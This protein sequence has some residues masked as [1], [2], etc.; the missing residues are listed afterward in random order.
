MEQGK[1]LRADGQRNRERIVEVASEL[2]ARE[3]AQAS[4]E[5]IAR[6]AGVG[7]ATLHRHFP[8][9]QALLEAVFRDGV[10]QLC[11]RGAARPGARPADE[12]E[13]WLEEVTVYTS[14]HQGLAAALLAGPEG[15]P[16][17]DICCTDM[18]LDVLKVL[19]SRASSAGAL[20][21]GAT[22]ED[23]L[24]LANAIA[25]ANENEPATARRVL[26]LALTG[27]RR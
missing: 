26:R 21:A 24:M 4:L 25:I 1:R 17:E 7:S 3:G 22:A 14:T 13:A 18:V 16:A 2:V 27:I 10:A 5:E 19:V 8:S 15:L 6:R 20:Q 11:A 12:L 23:L 9:R